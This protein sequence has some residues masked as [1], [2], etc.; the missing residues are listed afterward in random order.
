MIISYSTNTQEIEIKETREKLP[1]IARLFFEGKG[2]I[3]AEI[4]S[5][6]PYYPDLAKS[7]EIHTLTATSVNLKI[8]SEKIVVRGDLS[9]LSIVAENILGL[10]QH[11][12]GHMHIDYWEG[13]PYLSEESIPV[14]F[15]HF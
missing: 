15:D 1:D 10:A 11:G 9:K 14:V 8:E 4:N 12:G 3:Y 13:H 6:P 2:S 7:L 5:E